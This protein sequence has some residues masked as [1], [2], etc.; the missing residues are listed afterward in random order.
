MALNLP[1]VKPVDSAELAERGWKKVEITRPDGTQSH[2][3]VPLTAE[4]FLHPQE[5]Y[6]M[7]ISAFHHQTNDDLFDILNVRY[8]NDQTVEVFHDLL[9]DWDV[10]GLLSHSPDISVIF[11]VRGGKSLNRTRFNVAAEGT[12]PSLA[13]EI[14]SPRYR[15]EDRIEK[16]EEYAIAGVLEYVIFDQR[17]VRGE[18]LDEVLGYQ[19]VRGRYQPIMADEQGRILCRTVGLWMSLHEG[20]VII[21]DAISGE[22]LLNSEELAA[23]RVA[24]EAHAYAE[25]LAREAAETHAYEEQLAREAAEARALELETQLKALQA[26]LDRRRDEAH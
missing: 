13:I 15:K 18:T 25:Q 11:G 8:S 24:A 19:L 4:E 3:M 26:E 20:K 12:R 1:P 16:V 23:A 10:P 17:R 9:I 6:H 5:D 7:P 2:A 22:R 14:V 21:E